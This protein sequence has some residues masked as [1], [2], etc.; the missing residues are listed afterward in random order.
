MNA[1]PLITAVYAAIIG[2]L[3]VVL[4]GN[5]IRNRVVLKVDDGD[6][7]LAPMRM[8]IRAHA[9]FAQHAPLALLLIGYAESTGTS[10]L[11]IHGLG[12]VLVVARL[13]SAWGLTTVEGPSFGR[14]SGAGLTVLVTAAASITILVRLLPAMM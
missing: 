6:G 11:V 8:A 7:G 3:A 2:L 1:V 12:A 13:L 14:Q 9:N 5:V 4:T 10:R